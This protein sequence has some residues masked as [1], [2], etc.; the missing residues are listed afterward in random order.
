MTR[1]SSSN[2]KIMN[3]EQQQILL[4]TTNCLILPVQIQSICILYFD[5]IYCYSIFCWFFFLGGGD[6]WFLMLRNTA[7]HPLSLQ[8]MPM[9]IDEND[10][11]R[12]RAT[13]GHWLKPCVVYAELKLANVLIRNKN[14][15]LSRNLSLPINIS[16]LDIC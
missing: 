2:R 13:D 14:I 15:Y 7:N 6:Y 3:W 8:W 16:L 10:E 9:Q 1:P 4:T 5:L 12:H 11:N